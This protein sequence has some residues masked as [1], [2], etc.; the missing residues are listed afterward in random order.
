MT[1]PR[2]KGAVLIIRDSASLLIV[3]RL[4]I[5]KLRGEVRLSHPKLALG[6]RI[7]DVERDTIVLSYKWNFRF[8][9]MQMAD[10]S[11]SARCQCNLHGAAG[12]AQ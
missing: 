10:V 7:P 12:S 1:E 3:V 8:G 4:W 9:T 2:G 5:G 11:R 6:L